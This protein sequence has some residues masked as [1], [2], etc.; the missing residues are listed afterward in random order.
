MKMGMKWGITLLASILI[1]G[2]FGITQQA[3]AEFTTISPT[4][5]EACDVLSA[6]VDVDEIGN[7][8]LTG[9]IISNPFPPIEELTS[10]I[11]VPD[12]PTSCLSGNLDT[13]IL[14]PV[15]SIKNDVFPPEAFEEVWY[16]A[17]VDTTIENLDGFDGG[18]NR[19]FF[20]DSPA[21]F[22]GFG[23]GL[24]CPLIFES[25]TI[26]GIWEPG[27]TWH[28]ILQDFVN[29]GGAS[30]GNFNSIGV[31]F[32]STGSTPGMSSG[33]IVVLIHDEP[34]GGTSIPIDTTALLVAGDYTTA[35]WMIPILVSAVGIGLAVFTLKR[36]H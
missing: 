29:S 14:N 31:G 7:G 22:G 6:P 28:I 12:G 30:P 25:M 19:M 15:V 23:C 36:N 5:F 21:S 8:A 13:G 16:I 1:I 10:G 4:D 3:F 33:S 9:P 2:G 26:D 24:N 35:S 18:I 34:V 27:E 17:D 32:A 11:V 20:I